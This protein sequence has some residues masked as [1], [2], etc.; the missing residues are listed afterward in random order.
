M[1][2]SKDIIISALSCGGKMSCR[3]E[4][5]KFSSKPSVITV[6]GGNDGFCKRAKEVKKNGSIID[7]VIPKTVK[8][9]RICLISYLNGADFIHEVIKNDES[10][11]LH[12]VILLEDEKYRSYKKFKDLESKALA[13]EVNLWVVKA[14]I[15]KVKAKHGTLPEYIKSPSFDKPISIYSKSETPKTK[16]YQKDT[17][18]DYNHDGG[19]W[20]LLYE[21]R[22]TQDKIYI[23]QYVQP[24]IW[25]WLRETWETEESTLK[26]RTF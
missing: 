17:L 3:K 19:Y 22:Q 11:R 7:G 25:R 16:I 18:V 26:T 9:N 15:G 4:A 12:T 6:S 8:P 21:G 20:C 24:R 10:H 1:T 23:Q 13:G 5:E 14:S 2:V